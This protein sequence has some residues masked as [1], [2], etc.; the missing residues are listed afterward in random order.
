MCSTASLSSLTASTSALT[1]LP[2]AEMDWLRDRA[3]AC[4]G[5]GARGR[6]KQGQD[7]LWLLQG[8]LWAGQ[9]WA[10]LWLGWA[11][12]GTSKVKLVQ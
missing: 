5:S 10:G 6:G 2:R 4:G 1:A 9:G 8:G 7:V 3:C 12:E 11:C